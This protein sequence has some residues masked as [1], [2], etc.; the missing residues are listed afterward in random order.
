M[1]I[2]TGLD[3]T[4]LIEAARLAERLVERT[5]DGQVMK[6]GSRLSLHDCNG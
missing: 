5:L 3:L 1:G 2:E 4:R 6:A